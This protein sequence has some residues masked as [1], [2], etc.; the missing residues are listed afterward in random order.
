MVTSEATVPSGIGKSWIVGVVNSLTGSIP[1]V[2]TKLNL[3]DRLS[4]IK[5]RVG[6][7]RMHYTVE[8]G[9]Y[10]VG[11]P[12]A[13][14]PVFVSANYKLSFDH[15]RRELEGIDGWIMVIDTKGINV[16]CAAGKGTFGTEEII[17]RIEST[18][19]PEVVSHR[20]IIV[21][22]LGAPGVA[23]HEVKRRSSFRVI[24]GPVRA[25]D[26]PKFL[27]EGMNTSPEMKR[28]FFNLSD[29]I[30]L[31]PMELVQWSPFA[32]VAALVFFLLTGISRN[33]YAFPGWTGGREVVILLL[34]FIS[35]SA[36]VPMFLPWLPGRALSLKGMIT[37][38]LMAG[39]LLITGLIPFAQTAGHLETAAWILL[40]PAISAFTAMNFT[41]STTYTSLSGVKREMRYAIPAQ[42]A[43]AVAGLALWIIARFF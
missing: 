1:R 2:A 23:A 6:L 30:V 28:V 13:E 12:T 4:T 33:G 39:V 16:W 26:I 22:Q 20:Q 10:A 8:P 14:S 25:R 35:G 36:L 34:A 17:R 18:R 24:Y 29:R 3:Q 21:P 43:V 9:L 7:R 15:L 31:I 19:L 5:V 32:L 40:I 42:I 38:L 41:G 27:N 11:R 37:G